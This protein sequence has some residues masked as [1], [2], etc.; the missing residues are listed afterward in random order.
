MKRGIQLLKNPA[1]IETTLFI[2]SNANT[3]FINTIL[4]V[5]LRTR[6][7]ITS[8]PAHDLLIPQT[9]VRG[10]MLWR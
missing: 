3:F 1:S 7:R 5:R 2:L 4:Q 9:G 6:N 8:A 10:K